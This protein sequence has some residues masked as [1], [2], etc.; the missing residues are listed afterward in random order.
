MTTAGLT[1]MAEAGVRNESESS[2]IQG[3]EGEEW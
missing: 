3:E 2:K 1:M